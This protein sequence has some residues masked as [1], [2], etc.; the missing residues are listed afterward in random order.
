LQEGLGIGGDV[1]VEDDV[2]LLVED[3]D[4]H[5]SGVEIDAGIVSVGRILVAAHHASVG[6]GPVLS[7]DRGCTGHT[8]LK[9]P[10]WDK[11]TVLSPLSLGTGPAHPNRGHDEYPGA[12][13]DRGN[14]DWFARA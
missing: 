5:G 8:V 10:R 6:M 12:P 14:R 1:F 13:A 3:A 4:V 11:A 9:L 2:A 7:P